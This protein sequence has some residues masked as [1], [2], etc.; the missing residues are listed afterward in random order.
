VPA[1]GHRTGH[2]GPARLGLD[3]QFE[4]AAV[5]GRPEHDEAGQINDR[6]R[7]ATGSVITHWGLL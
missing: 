1:L 4:L 2:N 7:A 3:E 6:F 5:L